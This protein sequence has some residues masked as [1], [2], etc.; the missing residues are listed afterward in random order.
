M[1]V[2]PLGHQM[3]LNSVVSIQSFA[4]KNG[5][6]IFPKFLRERNDTIWEEYLLANNFLPSDYHLVLGPKSGSQTCKG[7]KKRLEKDEIR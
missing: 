1:K 3:K 7:C 4:R 2:D 6:L 5:A